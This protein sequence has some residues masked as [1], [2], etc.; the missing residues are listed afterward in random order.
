LQA[1]FKKKKKNEKKNEKR[2]RMVGKKPKPR[3]TSPVHCRQIS[4]I[5]KFKIHAKDS[6]EKHHTLGKHHTVI[7]GKIVIENNKNKHQKQQEKRCKNFRIFF[8]FEVF[9]FFRRPP[10]RCRL[11]TEREPKKKKLQ[12]NLTF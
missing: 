1:D 12:P 8:F 10:A 11:T 9:F 7:T 5:K 2:S 3:M 4:K 6:G